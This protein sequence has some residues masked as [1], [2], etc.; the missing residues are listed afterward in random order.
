MD[1]LIVNIRSVR[2]TGKFKDITGIKFGNLTVLSMYG[3]D[4]YGKILWR[5]KCDCGNETITLSNLLTTFNS[6]ENRY[7]CEDMAIFFYFARIITPH[8]FTYFHM[9][10]LLI[11]VKLAYICVD[12]KI[13]VNTN[14]SLNMILKINRPQIG[15]F[16]C[17]KFNCTSF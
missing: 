9:K 8:K 14:E 3:K 10:L 16:F 11:G 12:R 17:S 1:A 7:I 15:L 13:G 4:K 5:C 6:G 2:I